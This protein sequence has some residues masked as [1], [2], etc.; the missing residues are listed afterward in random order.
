MA[1]SALN[2]CQGRCAVWHMHGITPE[3]FFSRSSGSKKMHK[4]DELRV[5]VKRNRNAKIGDSVGSVSV[6]AAS[7][8]QGETARFA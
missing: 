1:E 2:R 5:P 8:S 3:T 4:C 7:V 6:S